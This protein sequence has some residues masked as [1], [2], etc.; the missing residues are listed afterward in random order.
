MQLIVI[1]KEENSN[2]NYNLYT[3]NLFVLIKHLEREEIKLFDL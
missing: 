2:L 1:R 3:T